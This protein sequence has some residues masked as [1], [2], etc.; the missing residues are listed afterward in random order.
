MVKTVIDVYKHIDIL[1][2]NAGASSRDKPFIE[3]TKSDWDIDLNVNLVGQM[4]VAHS[5]LPHMISRNKGRIINFSGG[6][7]IADIS[8]YG[9]AKAGIEAFTHSL[10]AE[11]AQFGVVVNGVAPG[12]G[13]TGL[14]V[15]TPEAFKEKYRR[16]SMLKR[17]CTPEDVGPVV[18]FM[19][20]EVCSYMTG[21]IFPLSTL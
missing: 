11:V 17:L 12:L 10:A 14:T 20:S 19:A 13:E 6:Q 3:T 1:V 8:I 15:E 21:Q 4:N 18:A 9:A 5:V 16:I 7:G 2:N